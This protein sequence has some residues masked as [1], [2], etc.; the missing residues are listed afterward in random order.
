MQSRGSRH[1]ARDPQR[2]GGARRRGDRGDRRGVRARR[3]ARLLDVH[4][5]PDHHRSV[6]T[7]AAGVGELAPALVAG[8]RECRALID[9]RRRAR[10]PPA[11]RA[12]S[13]SRR[14]STSTPRGAARRAPRRWSR[15]RSSGARG[16]RSSSTARSRAGARAPSCA[17]AASQA[18]AERVAAGELTPDFGPRT[19]DPSRGAVLVAARPPLVAFN[20][21]L[22]PPAT[23]ARR[24]GDRRAHPRGRRGGPAGRARARPGAARARRRRAGLDERRGPP[25]RSRSPR[26]SRRSR[27]TPTS[28]AASSSASR[29]RPRSTASPTTCRSATAAPSRRRSTDA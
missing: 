20:V 1:P 19:I 25:S 28:P 26:S 3:G 8:A 23:L 7:L 6:Y 10:Q 2:L 24:A 4:S 5:D 22:A 9:L 17:A 16:C 15:A 21:E 14:S 29:R 18:L 13:T 27:A 12:R 11:R